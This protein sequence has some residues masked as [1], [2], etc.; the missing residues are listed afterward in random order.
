MGKPLSAILLV[1]IIICAFAF[2]FSVHASSTSV[3]GLIT[4][5]T[6]WNQAGNPYVL[7][8]PVG[9]PSGVTLTIESGVTVDFGNYFLEMNGTLVAQGT[10]SNP[11]SMV[12]ETNGGTTTE[13]NSMQQI[14]FMSSI[15]TCSE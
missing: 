2:V 15:G 5:D 10:K 11:I 8:G 7:T 3:G 6:T 12:T 1:A 14:Q 9:V 4:S 13:S